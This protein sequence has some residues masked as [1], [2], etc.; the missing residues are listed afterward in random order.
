MKMLSGKELK[1]AI[2][3]GQEVVMFKYQGYGFW[4]APKKVSAEVAL[5][6][7]QVVVFDEYGDSHCPYGF[8]L[9]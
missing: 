1:K 5:R 4:S 3:E 7:A 8:E 9:A 2:E 6:K